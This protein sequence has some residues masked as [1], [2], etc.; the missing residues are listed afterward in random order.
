M[1]AFL[2]RTLELAP[3]SEDAFVDD[4]TSVFEDHINRLAA[5][6]ITKGCNPPVND[7]F[8]PERSLSRAEMATFI[9]RG[10]GFTDGA[11]SDRVCGR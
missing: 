3:T 4:D 2:D 9:V 6:D 7:Q 8:C 5:A 10:F 1:A 11:G